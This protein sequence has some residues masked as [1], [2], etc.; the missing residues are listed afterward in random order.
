MSWSR[1]RP[2]PKEL[3]TEDG[4]KVVVRGPQPWELARERE[5]EP[6]PRLPR[7]VIHPPG[8][9]EKGEE[10]FA[11]VEPPKDP[12]QP[13]PRPPRA[14]TDLD[15]RVRALAEEHGEFILSVLRRRG[16]GAASEDLRQNV[17]WI[18]ADRLEREPPL[19]N[20]QGYVARVADNQARN[21]KALREHDAEPEPD[22][23]REAS[24]DPDPEV[25]AA[26]AEQWRRLFRYIDKLPE[27][28]RRLIRWLDFEGLTLDDVAQVLGRSRSAIARDHELARHALFLLRC[29]SDEETESGL[30][31]KP[32][33]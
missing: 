7:V 16:C 19:Q 23:P 10:P 6:R 25:V 2:P 30:R 28:Q 15:R 17:L 29:R 26:R 4:V 11:R 18:L 33:P 27:E 9:P 13:A 24:S 21:Y 5:A 14:E 3:T 22:E 12:W 31:R 1:E 20:V 32:P 8:D